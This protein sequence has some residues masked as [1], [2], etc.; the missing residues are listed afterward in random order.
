MMLPSTTIQKNGFYKASGFTLIEAIVTVAIIAI[1]SAIA[2]PS[3]R[4]HA[5]HTN[6]S[7]VQ[8]FMLDLANREEQYLLDTR[9]YGDLS[10]LNASLPAR[11]AQYYTIAIAVDNDAT[12]P[13]YTITAEPVADTMQAGE[14]DLTLNNI[15]IKTPSEKWEK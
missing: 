13:S 6:R 11:T 8:Q 2:Y 1:L 4:N 3:Y 12:P 5:I 7:D 14:P 10:A 15:G 9:Q